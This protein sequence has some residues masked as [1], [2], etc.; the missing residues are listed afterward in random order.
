MVL[1]SKTTN[2]EQ[3]DDTDILGTDPVGPLAP[4]E[5]QKPLLQLLNLCI[6]TRF[7]LLIIFMTT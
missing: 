6:L 4:L 3:R 7:R 2:Y 5:G 1:D